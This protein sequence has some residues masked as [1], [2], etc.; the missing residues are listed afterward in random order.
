MDPVV[1]VSVAAAILFP[2]VVIG[3]GAWHL[4]RKWKSETALDTGEEWKV[5]KI[6]AARFSDPLAA[7]IDWSPL[8]F[9]GSG[10]RVYELVRTGAERREFRL[11]EDPQRRE[12]LRGMVLA[13]VLV[14]LVYLVVG[15]L[16]GELDATLDILKIGGLAAAALAGLVVLGLNYGYH[17]VF[18]RRSGLYW[19][20]WKRPWVCPEVSARTG[21]GGRRRSKRCVRLVDLHAL[22]ILGER[23]VNQKPAEGPFG[24]GGKPP[25]ETYFSYELNLVLHDGTRL[26][27]LDQPGIQSLRSEV[28]E[29]SEFLGIP[30]W[31]STSGPAGDSESRPT[32][33]HRADLSPGSASPERPSPGSP[34]H[35]SSSPQDHWTPP[36][37]AYHERLLLLL[38]QSLKAVHQGNQPGADKTDCCQQALDRLERFLITWTAPDADEDIP[39]ALSA[40][41]KAIGHLHAGEPDAAEPILREAWNRLDTEL[42]EAGG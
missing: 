15:F 4:Q 34:S 37:S 27:V 39:V 26:N 7:Q 35:E 30:V 11:T 20:T 1:V 8:R 42:H 18:D 25:P 19:T 38:G 24:L 28:Q 10:T 2:V 23:V 17:R 21:S 31:D 33:P 32:H 41:Q 16:Y 14:P 13:L 36:A 12:A 3:I 22:Q 5:R 6:A 40:I 29:L 9:Q